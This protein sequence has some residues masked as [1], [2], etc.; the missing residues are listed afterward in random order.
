MLDSLTTHVGTNQPS[1][2]KYRSPLFT[3]LSC[4]GKT[5]M[6]KGLQ[7]NRKKGKER[8]MQGILNPGCDCATRKPSGL[9]QDISSE[10]C[11]DSCSPQK[12]V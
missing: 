9:N 8:G 10:K 1:I 7:R 5:D 11:S 6:E 3:G 12:D 2:E 4:S